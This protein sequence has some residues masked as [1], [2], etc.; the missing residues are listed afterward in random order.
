[1]LHYSHK[2]IILT[3]NAYYIEARGNVILNVTLH[4]SSLVI[5]KLFF[6]MTYSDVAEEG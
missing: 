3:L 2:I 6:V 1:M 5:A 4:C